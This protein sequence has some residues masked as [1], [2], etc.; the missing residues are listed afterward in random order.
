M[1]LTN[2][3]ILS[4]GS[5]IFARSIEQK[6]ARRFTLKSPGRPREKEGK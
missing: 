4:H 6:L 1:G 5:E 3:C 2:P